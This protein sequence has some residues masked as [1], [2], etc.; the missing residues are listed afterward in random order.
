MMFSEAQI[1]KFKALSQDPMVI[2]KLVDALAP[3]I[4]E[5]HDVK[6]GILC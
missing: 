3:S 1:R 5:N 2:E 4:W 6:K